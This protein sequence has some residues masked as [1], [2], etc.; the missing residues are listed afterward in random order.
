ML[1]VTSFQQQHDLRKSPT[2]S[3]C[4]TAHL[5]YLQ[6]HPP[7]WQSQGAEAAHHPAGHHCPGARQFLL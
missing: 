6:P 2:P 4:L 1:T 5:G 3:R 7:G